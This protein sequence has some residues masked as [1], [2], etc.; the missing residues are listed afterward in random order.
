VL[1]QR[2][3]SG[4]SEPIRSDRLRGA[5]GVQAS[6]IDLRL[7]TVPPMAASACGPGSFRDMQ[8]VAEHALA[9]C[10]AVSALDLVP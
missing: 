5:D 10:M 9:A 6:G 4:P 1:V 3:R 8:M 2:D 7:R